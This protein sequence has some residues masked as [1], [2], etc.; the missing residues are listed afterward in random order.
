MGKAHDIRFTNDDDLFIGA[1]GDFDITESDT[2]HVDDIIDAWIGHWKEFPLVGVGI[3]RRHAQSGGIQRISRE[4]KIQ[5]KSD[6]Y[7]VK[8]IQFDADGGV[9]VTGKRNDENI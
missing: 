2:R 7:N 4:I 8:N 1:D 3:Q 5:L 9:Y 6:G